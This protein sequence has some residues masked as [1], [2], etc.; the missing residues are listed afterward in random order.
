MG[1]FYALLDS[2]TEGSGKIDINNLL[3]K[4]YRDTTIS[5]TGSNISL[6]VPGSKLNDLLYNP[7]TKC[8]YICESANTW[9][10]LMKLED[11]VIPTPLPTGFC[12]DSWELYWR[13]DYDGSN[14]PLTDRRE[15]LRNNGASITNLGNGST[16]DGFSLESIT[17]GTPYLLSLDFPGTYSKIMW[18]Y[19]L[20]FRWINSTGVGTN[21]DSCIAF[22]D[23]AST[24]SDWVNGFHSLVWSGQKIGV[25]SFDSSGSDPYA[26][27]LPPYFKMFINGGTGHPTGSELANY[28]LQFDL[29]VNWWVLE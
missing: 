16:N 29:I 4:M 28:R 10:Y 2:K 24:G 8:L 6:T 20:S 26:V 3:D 14:S 23:D 21:L 22:Y 13:S 15:L 11:P 7:S 9:T 1:A 17:S 27:I 18:N 19:S 25:G 12:Y 5:G